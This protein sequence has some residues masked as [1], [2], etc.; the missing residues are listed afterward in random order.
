MGLLIVVVFKSIGMV[1]LLKFSDKA[2]F[3]PFPQIFGMN[4]KSLAS[5]GD[6]LKVSTCNQWYMY[7]FDK[8]ISP[9]DKEF[10][11]YNEG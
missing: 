6:F 8:Q 5:L 11:G 4:M 10:F 9:A 3:V 1:N 2:I 7:E